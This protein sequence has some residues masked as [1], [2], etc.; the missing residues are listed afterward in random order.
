MRFGQ[1]HYFIHFDNSQNVNASY[2]S[3]CLDHF[4]TTFRP[5]ELLWLVVF[6][7]TV[8]AI[9][10]LQWKRLIHPTLIY[11]SRTRPTLG[12]DRFFA[13]YIAIEWV[14]FLWKSKLNIGKNN[15]FKNESSI[16]VTLHSI[17]SEW[18]SA[19]A[20]VTTPC[21]MDACFLR[22]FSAFCISRRFNNCSF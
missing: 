8:F 19:S 20:V 11:I 17:F 18:I 14:S 4:F 16:L 10:L 15:W 7:I 12:S 1:K 21:K 3:H 2:L 6:W 13:A 9:K 5:T 22:H